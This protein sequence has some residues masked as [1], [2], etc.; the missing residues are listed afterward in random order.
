MVIIDTDEEQD[1]VSEEQDL[2]APFEQ[3]ITVPK[4]STYK[5]KK[6]VPLWERE[7]EREREMGGHFSAFKIGTLSTFWHLFDILVF[8]GHLKNGSFPTFWHFS[9]MIWH[10]SAK[11]VALFWRAYA[12]AYKLESYFP[13]ILSGTI[14]FFIQREEATKI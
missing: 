10:L 11:S 14:Q 7:K 9:A 5:N 6:T 8:F 4:N 12:H 13:R 3:D 2:S 1:I